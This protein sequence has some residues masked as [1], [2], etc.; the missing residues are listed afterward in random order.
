VNIAGNL[1]QVIAG[2]DENRL[3]SP[4]IKMAYPLMTAVENGWAAAIEIL[5]LT[6]PIYIRINIGL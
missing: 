5:S 4:L 1:P 2:V 3:V 6:P